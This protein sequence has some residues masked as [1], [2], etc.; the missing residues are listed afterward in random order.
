MHT[1]DKVEDRHG[2]CKLSPFNF[3]ADTLPRGYLVIANT[4]DLIEAHG[5]SKFV[6]YSNVEVPGTSSRSLK[7]VTPDDVG[8]FRNFLISS[9]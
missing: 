3:G 8:T 6:I 4:I 1:S 7:L 9:I 2:P 5:D